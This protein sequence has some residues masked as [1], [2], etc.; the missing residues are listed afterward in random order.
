MHIKR[1]IVKALDTFV[2]AGVLPK[3]QSSTVNSVYAMLQARMLKSLDGGRTSVFS[4]GKRYI[5][6]ANGALN[7]DTFEFEEGK[8]KDLYFRS[9]LFYDW[10]ENASCPKFL[11]WMKDSL[12]PNQ[13]KLIQAFCRALLTGYTSGE[14]SST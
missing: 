2:A 7:S 10:N 3:Y 8:N 1:R 9:R 5:P 14:R 4:T 6:F 11:Q 12:R 13:E